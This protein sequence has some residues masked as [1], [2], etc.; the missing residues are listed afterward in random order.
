MRKRLIGEVD[1]VNFTQTFEW[2]DLQRIAQVEISSEEAMH[3]IEDALKV[4]GPG[5]RASTPGSQTIRI[6][7]DQPQTVRHVRLTFV[8]EHQERKQEFGLYWSAAQD[9][10]LHEIVRQ[11]FQFSPS[12]AVRE[13]EEYRADL[14]NVRI[15]ELRI[16]PD[17]DGGLQH[18]SLEHFLVA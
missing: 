17:R 5:W 18:A 8:E 6:V 3:P 14:T 15:L 12:G 7:F 16:E 11:Q 10:C 9:K 4:D 2:L 1:S 13:I